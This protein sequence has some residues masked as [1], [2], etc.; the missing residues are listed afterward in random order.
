MSQTELSLREGLKPSEQDL[1]N[2]VIKDT[3]VIEDT[4]NN[5][6][7]VESESN[8]SNILVASDISNMTNISNTTNISNISSFSNIVDIDKEEDDENII[9]IS[10]ELDEMKS[11]LFSDLAYGIYNKISKISNIFS[12]FRRS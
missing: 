9:H 8:N 2:L 11:S 12:F 1:E 5:I 4:V 7:L 10:G 3:L 6:N